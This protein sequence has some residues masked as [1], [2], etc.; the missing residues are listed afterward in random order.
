MLGTDEKIVDPPPEIP[1][2]LRASN[3]RIQ[4]TDKRIGNC[5]VS[6]GLSYDGRKIMKERFTRIVVVKPFISFFDETRLMADHY[7][8]KQFILGRE[9]PID[10]ANAYTGMPSDLIHRNGD[11]FGS[12]HFMCDQQ[13][14]FPI[15]LGICSQCLLGR[16]WR[17]RNPSCCRRRSIPVIYVRVAF[18][19]GYPE[20][21]PRNKMFGGIAG[22]AGSAAAP[23]AMMQIHDSVRPQP[24]EPIVTKVRVSAFAG[25]DLEIILRANQIDTLI[26]SGIATSGVVLSTLR[27]AA[28]KDFNLKV[29]SDACID[30]DPE[31]HRVLIEKVFPEQSEVVTVDAWV[32]SLH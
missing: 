14:L 13:Q 16:L 23:E 17:R 26:L 7:S 15:S 24:D 21:S 5:L 27:E 12:K 20:I 32:E 19:G 4:F 28:D 11:A 3:F 30:A 9:M 1:C 2:Y 25:S 18:R 8:L 22:R 10:G 29:L 6:N 31:V